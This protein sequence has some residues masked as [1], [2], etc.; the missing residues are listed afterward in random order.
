MHTCT[1][2]YTQTHAWDTGGER[3]LYTWSP[4]TT[5]IKKYQK[6]VKAQSVVIKCVCVRESFNKLININ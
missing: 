6:S 3:D 4:Y 2:G 1:H 5:T